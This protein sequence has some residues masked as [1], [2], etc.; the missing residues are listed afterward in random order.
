MYCHKYADFSCE[1]RCVFSPIL[2]RDEATRGLM[3][4]KQGNRRVTD[5]IIDFHTMAADSKWNEEA[6]QDVF[7]QALNDDIKDEIA[8]QDPPASL[9]ELEN[10]ATHIDLRL[11]ERSHLVRHNKHSQSIS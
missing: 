5:L 2:P 11:Q 6:L 4:L 1:L 7:L 9:R 8:T 3:R 10:L